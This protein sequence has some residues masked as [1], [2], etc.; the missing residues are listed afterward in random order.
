MAE[1]FW[2]Q[3]HPERALAIYRRVVTE[4]PDN[5]AAIA[6]LKELQ[7]I[8]GGPMGFKEHMQGIVDSVPGALACH[9]MGYDGIPVDSVEQSGDIDSNAVIIEC[10]AALNPLRSSPDGIPGAGPITELTIAGTKLTT[11][12]HPISDEHFLAVIV[13]NGGL[14]GKARYKLRVA[15][16]QILQDIAG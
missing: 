14:V 7:A 10:S 6:R 12:I 8:T 11:I 15:I 5:V 13:Q 16:P 1:Q 4:Q 3:G 2:S 9:L